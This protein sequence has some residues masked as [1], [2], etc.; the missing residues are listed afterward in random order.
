MHLSTLLYGSETRTLYA[1]QESRLN[2][3][4]MRCLRKIL[5]IKWQESIPDTVVLFCGLGVSGGLETLRAWI[6]TEFPNRY[7]MG[8]F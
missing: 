2:S 4:H 6:T 8:N 3:F 7:Y 1:G 5:K